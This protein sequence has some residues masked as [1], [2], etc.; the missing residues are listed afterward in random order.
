MMQAVGA[1]GVHGAGSGV[2]I[3]RA[4]LGALLRAERFGGRM[5]TLRLTVARPLFRVPL[6]RL[7]LLHHQPYH[8]HRVQPLLSRRAAQTAAL[9]RGTTPARKVS[10]HQIPASEPH[11]QLIAFDVSMLIVALKIKSNK[12]ASFKTIKTMLHHLIHAPSQQVLL[13]FDD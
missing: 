3:V 11:G 4:L 10:L 8:L 12:P 6:A 9:S 5:S 13:T 1:Q 7:R 2:R